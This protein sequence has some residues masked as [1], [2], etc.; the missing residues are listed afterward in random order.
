MNRLRTGFTLIELLVVVS[1]IAMLIAILL[2]SMAAARETARRVAC[3][4]NLHQMHLAHYQWAID[5]KGS[6]VEGQPIY[7][8]QADAG[9]RGGTGHYALWIRTWTNPSKGSEYGGSYTKEGAL[10]RR[11]YLHDGRTFYC[12]SW[13]G[14][15]KYQQTGN[16]LSP[17]G[18]GWYEKESDVPA[19]QRYMQTAY[20]YNSSF[21]ADKSAFIKDWRSANVTD[22]GTIALKADAFSD[23]A[24]GV[25]LHHVTGY[26]DLKLDGSVSFYDDPSFTIRD[27]KGGT[28]YSATAS[29]YKLF[30]TVAWRM[31]SNN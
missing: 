23:P 2:P 20:H 8:E 22:P 6:F 31:L 16:E 27:L 15:L 25:D 14:V 26:N 24:R 10:V 28:S 18:G 11:G 1:I 30:Q 19:A 5:H 12:P 13:T 29:D 7:D 3:G 4:S 21:D 9:N 17:T